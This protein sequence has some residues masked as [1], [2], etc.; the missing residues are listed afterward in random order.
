M[1]DKYKKKSNDNNIEVSDVSSSS[2]YSD[3]D[4]HMK[5]KATK[6]D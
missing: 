6:T 3:Y 1:D 2:R 4:E 5:K